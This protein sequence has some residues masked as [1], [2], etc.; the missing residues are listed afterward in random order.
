MLNIS[1]ED[2]DSG[3]Q[4]SR[5]RQPVE[6]Y[7]DTS[8]ITYRENRDDVPTGCRRCRVTVSLTAQVGSQVTQGL[9]VTSSDVIGG[10]D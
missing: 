5:D 7:N 4:F 9:A 2:V 1:Y 6:S 3:A 8:E 10:H